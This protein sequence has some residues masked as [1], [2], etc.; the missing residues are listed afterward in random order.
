MHKKV[1]SFNLWIKLLHNHF[2]SKKKKKNQLHNTSYICSCG[3]YLIRHNCQI[4]KKILVY[5][6]TICLWRWSWQWAPSW[7]HCCRHR[8]AAL[9]SQCRHELWGTPACSPSLRA[10]AHTR[11]PPCSEGR[12][13]WNTRVI[14]QFWIKHKKTVK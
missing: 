11:R 10:A 2:I 13:P 12:R 3:L 7:S 9:G 14:M 4:S 6:I 5:W 8:W 1:C